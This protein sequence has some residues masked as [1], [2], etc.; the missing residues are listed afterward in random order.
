MFPPALVLLHAVHVVTVNTRVATKTDR[1]DTFGYMAVPPLN[2]SSG[3]PANWAAVVSL[4]C[5]SMRCS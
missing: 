5:L 1:L 2:L 3:K 4:K